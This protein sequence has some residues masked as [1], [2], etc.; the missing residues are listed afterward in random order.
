M[1][2]MVNVLVRISRFQILIGHKCI[3]IDRATSGNVALDFLRR[4]GTKAAREWT[5]VSAVIVP[6]RLALLPFGCQ[7]RRKSI[8]VL[9]AVDR[10][11]L[12]IRLYVRLA[13]W[14]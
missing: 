10:F 7:A 2:R 8:G 5:M 11:L 4:F 6:R 14:Q 13:P 3:G 1:F 9:C 12:L